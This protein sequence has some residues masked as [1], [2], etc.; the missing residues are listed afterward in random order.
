MIPSGEYEMMEQAGSLVIQWT[1]PTLPIEFKFISLGL[2]ATLP[3][4]FSSGGGVARFAD[5]HLHIHWSPLAF[6]IV[7]PLLSLACGFFFCLQICPP[8]FRF[9][10]WERKGFQSKPQTVN[11]RLNGTRL[12]RPHSTYHLLNP[13]TPL[14]F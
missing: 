8:A 2:L 14:W 6:G 3:L 5:R 12:L 13:I 9:W 10:I 1:G 7:A 11:L 4:L